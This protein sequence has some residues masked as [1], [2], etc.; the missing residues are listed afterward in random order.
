MSA[1]R[2][3]RSVVPRRLGHDMADLVVDAPA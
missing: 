3:V 2:E 1:G